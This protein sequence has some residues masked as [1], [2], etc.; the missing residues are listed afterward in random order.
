MIAI[1]WSVTEIHFNDHVVCH[2]SVALRCVK[3][4]LHRVRMRNGWRSCSPTR[5]LE[6]RGTNRS[7]FELQKKCAVIWLKQTTEIMEVIISRSSQW[8]HKLGIWGRYLRNKLYFIKFHLLTAVSMKVTSAVSTCSEAQFYR[9]FAITT[10]IAQ[11]PKDSNLTDI[12]RTLV[13]NCSRI[14]KWEFD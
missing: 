6:V 4:M 8:R 14:I 13:Y 10:G 9:R 5:T 2:L 11:H 1:D 7:S 12:E 3:Q